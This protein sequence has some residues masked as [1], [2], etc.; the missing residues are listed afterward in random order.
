LKDLPGTF[1][2]VD[3]RPPE[4]FADYSLPDS[5]NADIADI[6]S[7]QAYLTGAGPLIIVDRDGSL[8]MAVGGILSQETERRIKVLYGGLETYWR[9]S[10]FGLIGTGKPSALPGT[11][12]PGES[13]SPA[14]PDPS[15]PKKPKKKSAGC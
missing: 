11:L 14:V 7:N 5:R 4:Q 1:T 3:I 6:L 9:E 13:S 2:L 15:Q 8:A 10:R 12:T